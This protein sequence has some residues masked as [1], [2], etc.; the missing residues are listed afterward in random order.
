M[1]EELTSH[2]EFN[3]D[4]SVYHNKSIISEIWPDVVKKKKRNK[5]KSTIFN[6]PVSNF[7]AVVTT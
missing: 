6:I 7:D 3:K 2:G 4:M 1:N 5:E